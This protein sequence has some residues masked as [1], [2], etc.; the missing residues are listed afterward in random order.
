MFWMFGRKSPRPAALIAILAMV[1]LSISQGFSQE[2]PATLPTTLPAT[3][4]STRPIG[5]LPLSLSATPGVVQ[6]SWTDPSGSNPRQFRVQRS[7]DQSK[8][9]TLAT[10]APGST[11]Y[12]DTTVE[13]GKNYYY[14]VYGLMLNNNRLLAA[15]DVAQITAPFKDLQAAINGKTSLSIK[16]L[17]DFAFWQKSLA[18][19]VRDA[20][21]FVPRL[22]VA[23]VLF[24]IF[25][26]IYRVVR[27][28]VM[29]SLIQ[30]HVD[31]SIRDLLSAL[32]KWSI[33]GFGLVIACNQI[34]IEITALLTGVSI[35]GLAIGFA[36]QETIANFIAGVV[37][38]W[39]KPFKVRDWIIIDGMFGQVLRISFRSTRILNQNGETIV[40]P[41]T[42]M[43][44]NK[45]ANHSTHPQVRVDVPIGIT[46]K[47]SID[48][49]RAVL[50]GLS[51]GD[52]RI[53]IEPTPKVVVSTCAGGTINLL[54]WI[55]ITDESGERTILHEYLEKAKIAL[56]A[57]KITVA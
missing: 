6:L 24:M 4:P 45:V 26:M 49:A 35:L 46:Y 11:A 28:V 40:M 23:L 5:A 30:S 36:A 48:Q 12:Q 1:L 8:W 41:N 43:L 50:V 29:G 52:S 18:D 54:L 19:F 20:I 33:L 57:A 55:W 25:W 51:K 42:Y 9:D 44:A 56:D 32:L 27:R 7:P 34:G 17:L 39:D 22:I 38:F 3:A 31:N 2:T 10:L 16:D 37:I 21:L 47:D 13:E 15:S 14:R 53:A